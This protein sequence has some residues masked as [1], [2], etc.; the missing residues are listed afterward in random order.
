MCTPR[1]PSCQQASKPAYREEST[2]PKVLDRIEITLALRD[3]TQVAAND[4]VRRHPEL[5]LFAFECAAREPFLQSR[6]QWGTATGLAMRSFMPAALQS[7]R[8][9][10]R[11]LAVSAMMAVIFQ[12][13]R[14]RIARVASKPSISGVRMSISTRS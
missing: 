13:G 4:A 10:P 14:L 3:Q 9:S 1:R 5:K 2:V 8:F 12:S 11:A 7:L 6:M